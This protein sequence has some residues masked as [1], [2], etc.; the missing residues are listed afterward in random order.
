MD[1]L[2]DHIL[3]LVPVVSVRQ[4]NRTAGTAGT[5]LEYRIAE[6]QSRVSEQTEPETALKYHKHPEYQLDLSD[7]PTRSELLMK[8]VTQD[9]LIGL[10][11]L[12]QNLHGCL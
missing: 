4:L 1:R 11:H 6:L 9:H 2:T 8:V 5:E 7:E 12:Y 3:E 10:D